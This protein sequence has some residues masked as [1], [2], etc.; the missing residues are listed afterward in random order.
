MG[1]IEERPAA[2]RPM[3]R[4]AAEWVVKRDRGL[5]LEEA[6]RYRRWL[7]GDPRRA[8]RIAWHEQ[9][10]NRFAAMD[11]GD[12]D[13]ALLEDAG[14]EAPGDKRRRIVYWAGAAALAASVIVVWSLWPL[15]GNPEREP[16]ASFATTIEAPAYESRILAD[17][18]IVE[19]K[20]GS[21]IRA[22]FDEKVRAVWL[23]RGEAHFQVA[24]ET[25]RPF[26]VHAGDASVRA[27][28]TAF[29]VRLMED[30]VE[31]IV[32]EGR[33]RMKGANAM[34]TAESDSVPNSIRSL[35]LGAFQRSVFRRGAAS[36]SAA[37]ES[38]TSE[39]I[40]DLLA[41]KPKVLE[42]SSVP[43]E[44]VV[45]AFNRRN[46]TKLVLA[47]KSLKTLPVQLAFRSNEVEAFARMLEMAFDIRAERTDADTIVLRSGAN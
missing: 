23:D 32:T 47:D 18:T 7:E 6:E 3:D 4:E 9:S 38:V 24:E 45:T 35:E 41:W 15:P 10:W 43:L 33:I 36:S 44:D 13:P 19:L 46:E 28:G 40:D 22:G 1:P 14:G 37:I 20:G 2:E 31:I 11:E 34:A 5:S 29:N 16:E 21:S 17:G 30:S 26:V 39:E 8:E 42:F 12:L 25:A 27:V